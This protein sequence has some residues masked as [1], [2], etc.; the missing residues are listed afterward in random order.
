MFE[1]ITPFK[2]QEYIKNVLM[3]DFVDFAD[4][5][6]LGTNNLF[7]PP[8]EDYTNS[9][10]II[11]F[12]QKFF[13]KYITQL[14]LLDKSAIDY[15]NL[16]MNM[17]ARKENVKFD[18]L[19]ETKQVCDAILEALIKQFKGFPN[20]AYLVLEKVFSDNKAHLFNLLPQVHVRGIHLF[21]VRKGVNLKERKDLFHTPYQMR[22]K[23]DTA[24]FSI[25]GYPSL[26]LSTS[27]YTACQETNVKNGF[28]YSYFRAKKDSELLM[29]DLSLPNRQ[30]AF[31]EDYSLVLFYPL[32]VI[33]SLKVK[34]PSSPFK[35]E[36]IIPQLL[37]QIIRLHANMFHGFFYTS[38]KY[39]KMNF[40]DPNQRN[41]VLFVPYADSVYGYSKELAEKLESTLPFA[42][43][44]DVDIKKINFKFE[45]KD[46]GPVI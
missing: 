44:G 42:V 8:F 13:K 27:L 22:N 32:I 12:S 26:Y 17:M 41:V 46:F 40:K 3:K 35:P 31:F 23:C 36:Y 5:L 1:H 33:C 11:D 7:S 25:L 2:A 10:D 45:D 6:S 38:T 18:L 14:E 20:E 39:P 30:L 29:V 9:K 19:G 15:V 24:R 37:T 16:T 34:D 4:S 43:E 28:S 21:R